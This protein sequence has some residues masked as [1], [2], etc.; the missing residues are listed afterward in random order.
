M[1]QPPLGR[2]SNPRSDLEELTIAAPRLPRVKLICDSNFACRLLRVGGA[3]FWSVWMA[4]L[5]QAANEEAIRAP[6]QARSQETMDRILESLENLLK[7]KAFDK[8][9][10]IELAQHS[11]TGTSSIYARFK[12]KQSLILGVHMRLREQALACLAQLTDPAHWEGRSIE[13]MATETVKR[14]MRF[15][16]EHG[17]LIRAVLYLDDAKVRDRQAGVLRA[18]AQQFSELIIPRAPGAAK[19]I[20][21]AIDGC[22]RLFTGV[23]YSMIMFENFDE[24]RN[25]FADH[26]QRRQLV[27]AMTAI[28]NEAMDKDKPRAHA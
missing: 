13:E 8:I 3:N 5:E 1:L 14:A 27:V 26:Q 12:D 19:E 20:R 6:R 9:T 16:G 21:E 24:L 15:Y 10:M 11:G 22:S 28:I 23:T 17:S 2:L 18:A 4:K 25:G 7:E